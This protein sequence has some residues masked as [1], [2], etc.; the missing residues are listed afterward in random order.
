MAEGLKVLMM[1]G[2][3]VGKSSALAAIMDAFIT[4]QSKDIFTAK[5]TTVLTKEDGVKQM[6][7]KS[8]LSA[9]KEMLCEHN[10]RTILVDSGKTDKKWDYTLKLTLT[11]TGESMDITFTDING[12]FFEW[13]NTHHEMV[14]EL[15]KSYDVFIIAVDTPFMMEARNKESKLATT[16]VNTKYNCIESIH[17]FL[18]YIDDNEGTDAKLVIFVPIKCEYWAKKGELDAVS[19]AIR[20]DYSTAISALEQYKSVQIEILPIQTIGSAVFSEHKKAYI[21]D[22]TETF[23]LFFDI[24]KSSKCCLLPNNKV[25][26]SDGIEKPVT[27]GNI[28]EDMDAILIPGTD[29]VRPNSWF[30]IESSEYAPHNCEQ[31][32]FHILEFMFA[33]VVDAK[34]RSAE[35]ESI[36][37]K[38]FNFILN[39]GTLGL[40]DTLRD[41]F[42]G[43]TLEQMKATIKQLRSKNL[44]KYS[45]EGIVIYKKCHFKS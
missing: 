44:I 1:G 25:L 2:Q 14:V 6:S 40:W 30:R 13:G 41:I 4:G 3:R 38:A 21:F 7:I 19:A 33:K 43:I 5:D 45:G 11:E 32:A 22:W 26:L 16:V 12:E 29:I 31:L 17:T 18:T 15:V 28:R 35:N 27:K 20:E 37:S 36:I 8:K 24:N 23:L 42:G 34:I 9:V 39:V 10:G